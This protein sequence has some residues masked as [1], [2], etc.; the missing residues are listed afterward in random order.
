MK[1]QFGEDEC[2]AKRYICHECE[3]PRKKYPGIQF[4]GAPWPSIKSKGERMS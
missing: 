1:C 4:Y 2:W 3:I